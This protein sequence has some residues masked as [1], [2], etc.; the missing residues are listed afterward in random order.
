MQTRILVAGVKGFVGRSV[1]KALLERGHAVVGLGGPGSGAEVELDLAD[2]S[3]DMH[4]LARRVGPVGGIIH[5]AAKIS[6]TSCV[7]GAAR[8]NLITIAESP[9][10]MLEAFHEVHGPTHFVY[11]SSIKLYGPSE[12]PIDPVAGPF[13]PEAY[14]YGSAKLLSERL[15]SVSARRLG[16]GCAW[17]RPSFIYGPA[18]RATNAIPIF[19]QAC[20]RGE[21]PVLFGEGKELRDDVLVSDVAYCLVEACLRR[22]SGP[23]NATGECARTLLEVAE[24]SCRAVEAAGGP[25]GIEPRVDPSRTPKAWIDQRFELERSRR[26]LGYEPTPL[27]LGLLAQ[28]RTLAASLGRDTGSAS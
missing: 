4:A 18:Q 8:S 1:E 5:L 16:A 2:R 20:F 12:R 26:L 23:F 19:M 17:V 25:A 14:S 15:L 22:Q 13:R 10:R 9:V 6:R 27:A 28:A 21:S 24:A 11:C 3:L 7:D